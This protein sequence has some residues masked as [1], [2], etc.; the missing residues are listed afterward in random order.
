MGAAH[1]Q[2]RKNYEH[3][4][5]Q[6]LKHCKRA[7][8]W[9]AEKN[10][11]ASQQICP[12]KPRRNISQQNIQINLD[13]HCRLIMQG[14]KWTGLKKK[15]METCFEHQRKSKLGSKKN[16]HFQQEYREIVYFLSFILTFFKLHK[17]FPVIFLLM[18]LS[19]IFMTNVIIKL[20]KST[21]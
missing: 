16:K 1:I 18:F 19:L 6:G 5:S 11:S 13:N 14:K 15:I 4:N 20:F 8:L 12:K 3:L 10:F 17:I 21:L 9:N 2:S 7:S